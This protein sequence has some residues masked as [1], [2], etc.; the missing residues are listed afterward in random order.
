MYFGGDFVHIINQRYLFRGGILNIIIVYDSVFGNTEKIASAVAEAM[1]SAGEVKVV[2]V[3]EAVAEQV[4]TVD[5]LIAGSPTNGFMPT[6][7]MQKFLNG[8]ID[9]EC[10]G[11]KAAAF[12]TR[13]GGKDVGLGVRMLVRVGGFAAPRMAAI[14]RKKGFSMVVSPEGFLVKGKNN[15]W[16]IV[17]GEIERAAE[18]AKSVLNAS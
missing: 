5:L 15:T 3:D 13:V 17:E 10:K 8:L 12:D 7:A 11:V 18:W 6:P 2:R 9:N 1:R 16:S 14:L 4:K